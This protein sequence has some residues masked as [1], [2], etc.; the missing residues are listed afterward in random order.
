MKLDQFK[1]IVKH[2]HSLGFIDM[3]KLVGTATD[4][5][6]EAIDADKTVVVYGEMYQPV[7]D[8]AVTVGLSRLAQLKGFIDL[9]EKSTVS[10]TNEVRGAVSVPTELKFDDGAGDIAIYRFM[11]ESMANEQIKVPPFKGAT[12][13]VSIKPEKARIDRLSSYQGVLGSFEKRFI[14]STDKDVLNFSIGSGPTDRTNIPFAKG[15]TGTLK[16]Q[17]SWPLTQV[18]SILKLNDNEDVKM[19]FSD[20]GALKIDI[21]SGI[22]KY[23]YILPAGKA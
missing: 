7:N 18:L 17:W 11:S 20:M 19:H 1:D 23:S 21:D 2:T 8:I 6:I 14:V 13:N 3:V 9:H 4:A 10:V 15:I 16:H 22:G 12:W 5:K